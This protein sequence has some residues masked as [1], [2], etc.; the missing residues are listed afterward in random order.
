M[1]SFESIYQAAVDKGEIDGAV[2]F[3]RDV[4]GKFKYAKTFGERTLLSGERK[5]HEPSDIL[6]VASATK[7]MT[8][9]A[10][11][12]CVD[13]GLLSLS[14]DV[15]PIAPALAGKQVITSL[16]GDQ[17][18]YEPQASPI[19]LEHLLTHSSGIGYAFL[20]PKLGKWQAVNGPP[21]SERTTVETKVGYP[22]IY[23]PGECWSYG[24]SY[25]WA[26]KLIERVSGRSLNDFMQH[27]IF[28]P[29]AIKDATF[30]PVT[31]EEM[32]AKM[33][34][35][36]ASDPEGRGLA[37]SGGM[38]SHGVATDNFGGHGLFMSGEDYMKVMFSLLANDGKLL[39]PETV[40]RIFQPH[41]TPEAEKSMQEIMAAP[42]TNAFYAQGT[43]PD[44]KRN[45]G[46]AGLLVM[47][48]LPGYHGAHTL[49]W[50]G[51]INLTWF[52]DRKNGICALGAPQ[53]KMP[54]DV[55]AITR[56]KND[57]RKGIYEVYGEWKRCQ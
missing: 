54:P 26:G 10:A 34:N 8:A 39:K 38:D 2:L 30:F 13:D 12:Q 27:R 33:V 56:L 17:F 19:T 23:Q 25:D 5:A 15:M 24:A 28:S 18:V 35:L 11:L 1:A 3:A 21:P 36:N 46:L 7:L 44:V 9:I 14:A 57:F 4:S 37:V 55:A 31:H 6:A 42:A 50:G 51:G 52:I 48:D 32:K 41:L 20:D 40:D 45:H 53:L 16:D 49:A 29:L 22:L 43:G 47:E